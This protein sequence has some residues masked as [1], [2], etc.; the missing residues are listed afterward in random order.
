M[1]AEQVALA[2]ASIRECIATQESLLEPERLD[3]LVKAA[4]LIRR[5]LSDGGKLLLFG[6]GGSASDA[7]HIAAEFVGRFMRDRRALPALALCTDQSAMTAIANDFGFE[8][9]FARQLEAIGDPQDVAMAISTS[10]RSP[11]VLAGLETARSIGMATIGLTGPTGGALPTVVDVC[12]RVPADSTARIQES[13]TLIAHVLCQL[14][15][16]ELT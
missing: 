15:E 2:A 16:L 12:L 13:H 7:S 14:V 6:N 11:N 8:R 4:A 9:V 10:G 1:S 5:G 3:G